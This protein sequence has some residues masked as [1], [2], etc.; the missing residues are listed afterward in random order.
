MG[1]YYYRI[2]QLDH[3]AKIKIKWIIWRALKI[4]I[5]MRAWH[6]HVQSLVCFLEVINYLLFSFI[7]IPHQTNS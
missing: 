4:Y 1:E 3:H 2:Q 6:I 5:M 7:L